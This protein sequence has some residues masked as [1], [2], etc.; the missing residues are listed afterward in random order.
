M[1]GEV[2]LKLPF[3]LMHSNTD[4]DLAGFP[5]PVR[6]PKVLGKTNEET[7]ENLQEDNK[8]HKYK[9]I[10]L[11]PIKEKLKE[12]KDIDVDLIEHYEESDST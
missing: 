10:K 11:E 8:G 9:G 2:S 7:T 6:E 4:P 12:S 3:T 1:G 5:S